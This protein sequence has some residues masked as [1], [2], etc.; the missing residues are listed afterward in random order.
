M[1]P[2]L[3]AP[4]SWSAAGSS[5]R[6]NFGGY[7]AWNVLSRSMFKLECDGRCSDVTKV[8]GLPGVIVVSSAFVGLSDDGVEIGNAEF[9]PTGIF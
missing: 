6:S 1:L 4:I 7:V 2:L 9:V 3:E 8:S 5:L